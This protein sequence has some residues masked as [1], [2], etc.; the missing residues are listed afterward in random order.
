MVLQQAREVQA[1]ELAAWVSVE[2]GRRAVAVDGFLHGVHTKVGGQGIG[3]TPRQHPAARPVYRGEQIDEP[4][5]H[6]DVGDVCRPHVIGT[7]DRQMAQLMRIHRIRRM[8]CAGFG[9]AIQGVDTHPLHHGGYPAA[10]DW[11]PRPLEHLAQH[12]GLSER[13]LQMQFVDPAHQ[14]QLV[15]RHRGSLVVRGR[16]RQLQDLAL[17]DN[18]QCV[19][20]VDHRF[21]LNTPALVSAPSQ[22]SCSSVSCPILAWSTLRSGSA[23]LARGVPP[24][25]AADAVNGCFHSEIWFGCTA[26][27]SAHSASVLSPRI[28]A[29][30]TWALNPGAWF[31][32]VLLMRLLLC[33]PC[34]TR[35]GLSKTTTYRPVQ[36]SGT[37]S[38][39][40]Q[41]GVSH[42][43]LS[44]GTPGISRDIRF[45]TLLNRFP[46]NI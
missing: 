15:R 30:A 34:S 3:Q 35:L 14:C 33:W 1:G 25:T 43:L 37:T 10:P 29:K 44:W 12:S 2:D 24:N 8:P 20:S 16:A 23:A 40:A 41:C 42:R 21:A 9:L 7:G 31:L 17:P 26:K 18:R 13:V 38:H 6:W 45:E 5:L 39:S 22:Q 46:I 19:G 28:A 27:C 4:S 32:R 36:M 11:M